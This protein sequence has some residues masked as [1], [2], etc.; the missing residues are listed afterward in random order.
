M[1]RALARCTASARRN[2]D[3]P[4]AVGRRAEAARGKRPIRGA[5]KR[6]AIRES[7]EGTAMSTKTMPDSHLDRLRHSTG[8]LPV[9]F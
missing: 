6:Q 5:V 3:R 1:A 2:E 7:R 4:E 8:E 9:R